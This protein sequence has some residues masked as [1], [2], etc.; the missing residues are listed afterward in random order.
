[1]DLGLVPPSTFSYH[2]AGICRAVGAPP[3]VDAFVAE[4][5]MKTFKTIVIVATL[6]GVGYGAHV[7]LN[8]PVPNAD[9]GDT[10]STWDALNG[11]QPLGEAGRP[12]VDLPPLD[13]PSSPLPLESRADAGGQ[14]DSVAGVSPTP[15]PQ[16][17]SAAGSL[18]AQT[19]AGGEYPA[20]SAPDSP[21]V[22]SSGDA[23][24]TPVSSGTGVL[25]ATADEAAATSYPVSAA[26]LVTPT[27]TSG[28]TP[29]KVTLAPTGAFDEM[30]QT[31]QGK[32]Q[33]GQL[34]D[35]L[36]TLSLF[37][38]EPQLSSD[39]R[40]R[41]VPLLDQLAGTVIYSDQHYLEAPRVVRAGETIESIAAECGV[42]AEFLARINL[43]G[44]GSPLREG[45][46]LKVV[47]GP[48]RG[49]LSLE[50]REL[51]LFL[52]RYYAGRFSVGVGRDLPAQ[53]RSAEVVEISGPRPYA[54]RRTG[55]QVAAG[56]A[57]NPY[58]D[59]WIGL[60]DPSLPELADL[61]LHS[62]GRAVDASDTRGCIS[63]GSADADDLR[64]ILSIGSKVTVIR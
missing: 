11:P 1:V 17:A 34:V 51:T 31:V 13:V 39:Q 20:T 27:G 46:Q 52:G 5:G 24:A 19:L 15:G 36:F 59:V 35:A 28:P 58:G 2:P 53:V 10:D 8:K 30:W 55:Q 9:W 60:R 33:Q 12:Q 32:L 61:G 50:H 47:R 49:E 25:P 3:V 21:V 23:A 22:M 44:S 37:Y 18:P 56:A 26:G 57:D 40:S 4:D 63:V 64:A 41:L 54:D 16:S 42:P 6:L 62:V 7:V 45:Q 48:F 14:V 29:G 38:N 43:L